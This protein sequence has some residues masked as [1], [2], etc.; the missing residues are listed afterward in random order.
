VPTSLDDALGRIAARWIDAVRARARIVVAGFALLSIASLAYAVGH[1]GL[2]SNEDDLFS[3]DL[4]FTALRRDF[5]AAFPRLVDPVVV[6]LDAD[7]H[8]LVD[9]ARDRLAE[10]LRADPQHFVHVYEP[11]GGPFFERNGLLYLEVDE[12]YDLSDNLAT[13]QPYLAELAR[14]PSLRGFSS[15]L[16]EAV[17]AAGSAEFPEVELAQVLERVAEGVEA[18]VEGRRYSLSWADLVLGEQATP[19]KRRRFLV[20]QPAIDFQQVNPAESALLAL[21]RVIADVGYDG[22]DGVRA[23]VTGLYALAYEEMEHVSQQSSLAGLASFALVAGLLFAALGSLRLV[24]AALLTLLA[25]LSV[26]AGFAAVAVGHL[27]LISVAFAVLFIGLSIDYA[28]HLCTR[29]REVL[30]REPSPAAALREAARRVGGPLA[31]CALTTAIGFYAFV[32]TEFAGVAELGLIAGTSM[33]IGLVTNLTLLPALI[34]LWP[35]PVPA[36]TSALPRWTESLR[37]LPFRH[38]PAVAILAAVLTLVSTWLV[39]QLRFDPNP[40]HLRDPSA[41]SVQAFDELLADGEAFPWNVNVRAAAADEARAAAARLEDLEQVDYAL[42]YRDFVPDEQ[43]QKLEILQDAALLLGPAID[44]QPEARPPGADEQAAALAGLRRS[45]AALERGEVDAALTAAADRL[46]PALARFL[47]GADPALLSRLEQSLV[48]SLPDRLE[49]LRSALRAQPVTRDELPQD[50][51]ERWVAED[52]RVRVEVFPVGDLG[53]GHALE[54]YVEAVREIDPQAFGEGVAI[55]ESGRVV[56]K[57]FREALFSAAGAI[58]LLILLL[59]RRLSSAVFVAGT[60][61]LAGLLTGATAVAFG[62][63]LNFANVIVIPL[64][65]G[66]GVDSA[67]HLVNRFQEGEPGDREVLRTSTA[68]AVLYSSFT[69]IASFGTLGFSTHLGM[70]S[71]GQL[72]TIGIAMTLVCSLGV[73]PALLIL[74][75]ERGREKTGDAR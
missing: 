20:V 1:L 9:R 48:G 52:G 53:E 73:L 60:L 70:A 56:V 17:E 66:M 61:G 31:I 63:P 27:N 32:P 6:V 75:G 25:G 2:N 40:L 18:A 46:E 57:A 41:H 59:W 51:A 37:S 39:G 44:Q 49:R 30:A 19:E 47:E 36:S 71:L 58:F 33:L 11:G 21:R 38:A 12:L 54:S 28:I 16:R 8:D 74:A 26:T 67:I 5:Y 3:E 45:L 69:T 55:L 64:L 23:R 22:G 4:P 24:L 7:T 42:T 35:P 14:D 50:L 72:L 15:I 29:Y 10:R 13:A 34:C 65:L 62:I 68:R 43:E